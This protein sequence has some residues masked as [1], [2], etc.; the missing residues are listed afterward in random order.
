MLTPATAGSEA[1]M[2][3]TAAARPAFELKGVMSSLTVLRLR[4]KDLGLIEQQLRAKVTPLPQFFM[5]A[6]VVIDPSALDGGGDGV[7]WAGLA[8]V[9][10]MLHLVP[11]GVTNVSEEH[12]AAISVARLPIM[13]LGAGRMR[14]LDAHARENARPLPDAENRATTPV[15][16][17]MGHAGAE[18]TAKTPA[19]TSHAS[20]PK[21]AAGAHR[22]PLVV[23]QP[24]RSGQVV[25]ARRG[26]LVVLAPVNPGAEVV[27]DGHVH[28]YAP[29]RGRAIAGAQ[30]F[31]E[32]RI[33]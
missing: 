14:D 10:R 27:A 33:F 22:P 18:G 30:G 15:N 2:R 25:Y 29:L 31:T 8:A 24:V 17:T 1:A 20:A 7:A 12:R 6:P 11:V 19:P 13:P 4:T 28:I 21:A 5:D 23:R 26:D 3:A 9:L 32:A 16:E